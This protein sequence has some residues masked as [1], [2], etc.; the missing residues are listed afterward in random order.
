M[1]GPVPR[2]YVRSLRIITSIAA[3]RRKPASFET[4]WSQ[5]DNIA[6][7]AWIASGVLKFCVARNRAA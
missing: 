2:H 4:R 7:A 6:V 1:T 5:F 3:K